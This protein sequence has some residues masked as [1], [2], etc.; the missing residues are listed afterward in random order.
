MPWQ[1]QRG[2]RKTGQAPVVGEGPERVLPRLQALLRGR[3]GALHLGLLLQAM[4]RCC[5]L[6]RLPSGRGPCSGASSLA[7]FDRFYVRQ[8]PKRSSDRPDGSIE[9]LWRS[10][11]T[12]QSLDGNARVGTSGTLIPRDEGLERLDISRV[13]ELRA[14]DGPISSLLPDTYEEAPF[15][16]SRGSVPDVPSLAFLMSRGSVPDV[17]SACS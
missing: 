8:S 13:K 5:G 1:L 9:R 7:C 15:L 11:F 16:M 6:W 4:G 2:A 12:L 10:P 3:D 17:P 14:S